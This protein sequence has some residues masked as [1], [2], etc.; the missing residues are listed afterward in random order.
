[1]KNEQ[2]AIYYASGESIEKIEMLP[3]VSTVKAKGYEVLYLTDDVDEF[4]F[5]VLEKYNDKEF[6]NVTAE[7]LDLMTDEEKEAEKSKNDSSE[8]MLTFMKDAIGKVSAVKWNGSLADHPVCLSSEGELSIEMAKILKKMPGAEAGVPDASV[9]L[10][11]NMNHE[12]A[13]KLEELF[14][15]DKETLAKYANILYAEACLISGIALDDPKKFTDLI[16]DL[17]V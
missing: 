14:Q 6:K 7:A 11:I 15:S 4:A 5:R 17:M 1:M 9:A 13:R 12:I 8:D 3:Q 2:K 10:E 16:N